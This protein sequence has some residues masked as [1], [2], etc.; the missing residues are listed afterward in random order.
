MDTKHYL[1]DIRYCLVVCT[2]L[3]VNKLKFVQIFLLIL[4]SIQILLAVSFFSNPGH[5]P[6]R[7]LSVNKQADS[8]R[9]KNAREQS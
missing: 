5:Y 9:N 7:S 8:S 3:T 6:D 2:A 1:I 4:V